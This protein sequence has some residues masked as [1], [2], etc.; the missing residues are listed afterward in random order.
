MPARFLAEMIS[1][2]MPNMGTTFHLVLDY[3]YS[4]GTPYLVWAASKDD[5]RETVELFG[6]WGKLARTAPQNYVSS[7]GSS[8]PGDDPN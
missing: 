4:D 1:R 2:S 3:K 6:Q 7:D 8:Q 5:A